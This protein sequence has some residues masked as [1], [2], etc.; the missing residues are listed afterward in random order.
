VE[1]LVK[2]GARVVVADLTKPAEL[3]PDAVVFSRCDVT[4]PEGTRA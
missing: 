2:E 1:V 3:K 4:R